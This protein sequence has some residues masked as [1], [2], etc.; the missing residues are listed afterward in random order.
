[1]KKL[2]SLICFCFLTAIG[3][4]SQVE[5]AVSRLDQSLPCVNK[6]FN[7]RTLVTVDSSGKTPLLTNDRIIEIFAK[8]SFYFEPICIGLHSC[9]I[10]TIDNYAYN[11]LRSENRVLEAGI[12][13][14]YPNRVN[15]LFVNNVLGSNCGYSY[16][17][18]IETRDQAIIFVELDCDDGPAEQ[19]AHHMG[20]LL[21]LYE[22]NHDNLS[23]DADESNCATAGDQICD[24][25]SDPY[26]MI[27]MDNNWVETTLPDTV[28]YAVDCEFVWEQLKS[29][30]DYFLPDTRNIMSPYPCKCQFT[31]EQYLKMADFYINSPFKQY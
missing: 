12:V 31:P 7:V 9:E 3:L 11:S 6:V 4:Q 13:Y 28:G 10:E 25:A 15:V 21:G 5:T 17:R 27:S 30:G 26:G 2:I 18:G 14:A 23:E 1:M 22:T 24:T 20:K 19:I 8:A 16:F 29:N